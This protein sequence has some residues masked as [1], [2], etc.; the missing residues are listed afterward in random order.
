MRKNICI[1][2]LCITVMCS[3][4]AFADEYTFTNDNGNRADIQDNAEIFRNQENILDKMKYVTEYTNILVYTTDDNDASSAYLS[5][6]L[7]NNHFGSDDG[8]VF[9]IDM[10]NRYIYIYA[11][12]DTYEVITSLVADTI[13]DNCYDYASDE[14]Y[15]K[16]AE[17][18]ISQIYTKLS[19]KSIPEPM[20]YIGNFFLSIMIGVGF[21]AIFACYSSRIRVSGETL[22]D[23][24]VKIT[25]KCRKVINVVRVKNTSSSGGHSGGGGSRGS[26][27][28][29]GGHRF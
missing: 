10:D 17:E 11:H 16:C 5:E 29:G 1:I 18:A 28:G 27:G 21:T 19:G 2:V 23:V 4:L 26:S 15:D 22:K 25:D 13:T 20:R 14:N 9:L 3:C 24:N 8:V 7:A 12:N 6:E